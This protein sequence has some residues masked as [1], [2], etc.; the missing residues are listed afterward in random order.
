[1]PD[2]RRTD[3]INRIRALRARASN[4]AS[5]LAEA[6]AAARRVA[7][8]L[9][10][11][12]ITEAELAEAG[13]D[14]IA[15]GKHN[16][17]RSRLHPTMDACAFEIGQASECAS[18]VKRGANIWVGQPEDVEFAL[19]LC[20][21]IQGAAERSY[22]THWAARYISAPSSHYR[23]S[24]MRGFG[25]SIALRLRE[26]VCDREARRAASR[27]STAADG[28][29]SLVVLKEQLIS[30]HLAETRPDI[31]QQR[32]GNTREPDMMAFS[33]GHLAAQSVTLSRPLEGDTQQ[34]EVLNG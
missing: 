4:S 19:Y 18:L 25:S 11:N 6:E 13:A 32:R 17:G 1:M 9:S 2:D 8:L 27:S 34:Q 20:E 10:E 16:D 12:E 22:K 5:S 29:C 26:I 15:E 30:Q 7:K 28:S 3:V 23:T 21:M 33:A 31:K 14:S 24:Y